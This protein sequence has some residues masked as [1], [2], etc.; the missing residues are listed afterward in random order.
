MEPLFQGAS[1]LADE[2]LP[3]AFS[4]DVSSCIEGGKL[5]EDYSEVS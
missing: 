1:C 5:M 3:S 2:F 4:R